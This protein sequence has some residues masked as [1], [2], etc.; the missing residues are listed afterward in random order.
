MSRCSSQM[1]QNR[2]VQVGYLPSQHQEEL[3]VSLLIMTQT[4]KQCPVTKTLRFSST[5]RLNFPVCMRVKVKVTVIIT[6]VSLCKAEC[7][8]V[9][10]G[11]TSNQHSVLESLGLFLPGQRARKWLWTKKASKVHSN[12]TEQTRWNAKISQLNH[13]ALIQ[14]YSILSTVTTLAISYSETGKPTD[15]YFGHV[16]LRRIQT[17]PQ[18]NCCQ[19]VA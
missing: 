19:H 3:L 8:I 12:F 11:P 10:F 2:D 6:A 1:L 13:K 15:L 18:R 17:V 4:N 14:L 5:I 16:L 9:E 7:F